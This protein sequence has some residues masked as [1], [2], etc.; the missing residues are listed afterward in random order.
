MKTI[1]IIL[2]FFIIINLSANSIYSQDN[3]G[4]LEIAITNHTS[5]VL[6]VQLYPISASY[7]IDGKC[8]QIALHRCIPNGSSINNNYYDY[9]NGV[10]YEIDENGQFIIYFESN[11]EPGNNNIAGWNDDL[12]GPNISALGTYGFG[13]YK[14][15][16]TNLL[17]SL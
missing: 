7:R 16:V 15:I 6:K 10:H 9:N 12:Q 4:N 5:S 13:N 14:F 3:G 17:T 8:S 1:K 2:L 11:V